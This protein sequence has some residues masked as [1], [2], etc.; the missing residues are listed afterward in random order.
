MFWRNVLQRLHVAYH[1]DFEYDYND[2][3]GFNF[4]VT[5]PV[6]ARADYLY[7]NHAELINSL[8]YYI[9]DLW[10]DWLYGY[11]SKNKKEKEKPKKSQRDVV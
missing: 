2:Y 6:N 11:I 10:E 1:S 4:V 5:S 3:A 9:A 8:C 7:E